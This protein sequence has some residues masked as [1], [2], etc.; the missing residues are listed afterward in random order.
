MRIR[1]AKKEDLQAVNE[2]YNQAVEERFCTAHLSPVS[3][4]YQE[5]WFLHH[6]PDRYP[7]YVSV[8]GNRILGWVSLGAYRSDRQALAHVGE[9]SYYVHREEH[10]KGV[11]SRLMEHIIS[12][13]PGFGITILIAILLDKNPASIA[14]LKKYGFSC[15]GLYVF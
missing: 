6:D 2:I 1:L 11:G 5:E 13:A 12:V 7:V 3:L 8:S 14:L 4:E 9:V 15:W 10:G